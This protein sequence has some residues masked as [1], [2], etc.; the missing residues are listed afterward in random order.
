MFKRQE[1]MQYGG[2]LND[3]QI[4][5]MR[6]TGRLGGKKCTGAIMTKGQALAFL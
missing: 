5:K 1:A 4:E 6:Q 3:L 2:Y